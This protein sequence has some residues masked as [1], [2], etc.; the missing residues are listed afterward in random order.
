MPT[1]TALVAV[2][3]VWRMLRHPDVTAFTDTLSPAVL[4]AVNAAMHEVLETAEWS[5]LARHDGELSVVPRTQYTASFLV[6]NGSAT[7][8]NVGQVDDATYRGSF[9]T[10]LVVTGSPTHGQTSFAVASTDR[11]G[12]SDRYHCDTTWPGASN[13]ISTLYDGTVYVVDYQLPTTVRDVLSVRHE[14]DEVKVQFI[15]RTETFDTY[16]PTAHLEDSDSPDLVIVGGQVT[17]T[18]EYGVGSASRAL[19]LM[20][21]P[22]PTEAYVLS[23]SYRYLQPDLSATTDT[24][25]AP[26]SIVDLIVDK[27]TARMYR[28]AVSNDPD[29]AERIEADVARRYQRLLHQDSPMP[30]RRQ[31]LRSHDFATGPSQFGSRPANS[32]VFY[33]P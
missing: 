7:I 12:I 18:F 21:W 27:A 2:N 33:E 8:S 29:M 24:I 28:S 1:T 22:L 25:D 4:D 3:R 23:Y 31:V 19:G 6:T 30:Q 26:N 32:R 13:D 20:V 11:P 9:R 17:S 16:I 14:E 5:F 15:D 10:R